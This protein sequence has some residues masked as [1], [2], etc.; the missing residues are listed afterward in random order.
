MIFSHRK[1]FALI[2]LF[3]SL[4]LNINAQDI[5]GR[6]I[7]QR[8]GEA[9]PFANI[10][11]EGT[12]TGIASNADG[13]FTITIPSEAKEGLLAISAVGFQSKT[14]AINSLNS[15]QVNIITLVPQEYNIDE[16]DVE[17]K[18]KVLY[19]AI[20]KC[21]QN[22]EKNYISTPYSY[23]FSYKNNGREAKGILSDKTGYKR[24]SF[25]ESFKNINYQFEKGKHQNL[26]Y[27]SGKTNMEDL[28]SFDLV[29]ITGNIIDE[30]NVYDYQL[31]L[32][33]NNKDEHLW[34]I[35]FSLPEPQLYNTGDAHSTRYEG[36]IHIVKDN[37]AIAK[38]VVR[39]W[40]NKRSIHG[41]SVYVSQKSSAFISDLNY[42]VTTTY[43]SKN[44]RY[45]LDKIS[46][47]EHFKNKKGEQ[48]NIDS[49]LKVNQILPEIKE[50]KHRDYFVK[51]L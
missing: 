40:S 34:V 17:A 47:T 28:L 36:E 8:G 11:V 29:R 38:I 6:I 3:A 1:T 41:K 22:I 27:F 25:Q 26:P 46:M 5:S 35:K 39:G 4:L 51:S 13:E 7:S 2:A 31:S 48:Q 19:G 14:I 50:L 49:E 24:S 21:S 10:L 33:P 45:C 16:V 44:G 18:S 12:S 32:D 30:Q 20:K 37:F 42:E 15:L 43:S 23:Q 9:V